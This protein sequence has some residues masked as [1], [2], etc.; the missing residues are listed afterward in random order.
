MYRFIEVGESQQNELSSQA[1]TYNGE[2]LDA[3]VEGF[4]VLNVRGRET[5]DVD[6]ESVAVDVG[7]IVTHQRLEARPITVEYRLKTKDTETFW[8]SYRQLMK[9]LIQSKDVP[10]SFAD[11]DA[12]Y[13]GRYATSESIENETND[14]VSSFEIFRPKPFKYSE[15][16]E[17]DGTLPTADQLE[18]VRIEIRP[19]ETTS[20]LTITN[21]VH[22]IRFVDSMTTTDVVTLDFQADDPMESVT[23]NGENFAYGLAID[24]DYE[25]FNVNVGGNVTSE[26]ADLTVV[27]RERWL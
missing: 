9:I 1:M 23:K 19:I 13:Y 10:F 20:N 22:E 7:S 3:V 11:E 12:V 4:E 24:S 25:N 14:V 17:T 26:E 6:I 21:G 8:A 16:I 5:T 2:L 27:L 18:L 15:D